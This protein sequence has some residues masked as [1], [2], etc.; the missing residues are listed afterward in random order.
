MHTTEEFVG[1]LVES[2]LR[3]KG[4]GGTISP[5]I[6][7]GTLQWK[8]VDDTGTKHKFLIPNSYYAPSG[9]F[10]L[11]SPQHWAQYQRNQNRK[12]S[13]GSYDI[14][15]LGKVDKKE[16]TRNVPLR[17]IDNVATFKLAPG[18][19]QYHQ[20]CAAA[21]FHTWDEEDPLVQEP[22][23]VSD[24]EDTEPNMR[25]KQKPIKITWTRHTPSVQT[26][27]ISYDKDT[28]STPEETK[29]MR[30]YIPI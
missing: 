25:A 6:K 3:I 22:A 29:V 9:K 20:F 2:T 12:E 13:T 16:F 1:E 19:N 17:P 30:L 18:Y 28:A 21:E 8:C 14:I 11:L 7:K 4:F 5:L 10:R 27:E 24:V 26:S 23:M 15:I